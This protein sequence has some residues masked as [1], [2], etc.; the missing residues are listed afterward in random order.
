VKTRTGQLDEICDDVTGNFGGANPLNLRKRYNFLW[1]VNGRNRSS[2]TAHIFENYPYGPAASYTTYPSQGTGPTDNSALAE[3]LAKTNPNKPAIDLPVF[4]FE[5]RDLPGLVRDAGATL[6]KTKQLVRHGAS[7]RDVK[8]LPRGTASGYLAWEFGVKPMID[9]VVRML[10]FQAIVDKRVHAL[11]NLKSGAT[12]RSATVWQDD[13][14]LQPEILSYTSA[15]YN[16]TNRLAYQLVTERRKWVSTKW[17]SLVPLPDTDE[18]LRRLAVRLAFGL[19]ISFATLWQA[20]PWS[21]LIDWF[22]NVGDIVDSARNTIP[23]SHTGSCIMTHSRTYLKK[24]RWVSRPSGAATYLQF[25]NFVNEHK[26]RI[27]APSVALPEFG[28]PFLNG[29]QLSILSAIGA[30]RVR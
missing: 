14:V 11:N 24:W 15:L 1:V 12:V 10:D 5:L 8:S 23:V 26:V 20:M 3:G 28:L 19:D 13:G 7:V 29:R 27:P 22:S 9:D 4:V 17:T 2:S 30:Q 16:D 25:P 21:W 18:D 6:L